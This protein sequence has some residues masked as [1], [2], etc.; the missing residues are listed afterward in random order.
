MYVFLKK[1]TSVDQTNWVRYILMMTKEGQPNC[2]FHDTQEKGGGL[3]L[4]WWHISIYNT[5]K[6]LWCSL[7]CHYW[8][9]YSMTGLL[10][11]KY[12]HFWQEVSLE[13]LILR[14]PLRPMGL[15]FSVRVEDSS[16]SSKVSQCEDDQPF[17][18]WPQRITQFPKIYWFIN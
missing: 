6:G 3:E 8:F 14:W 9:I 2:K 7:L 4:F 10:I 17:D 12:E 16:W 1:S 13:S 15:L 5:L 11:C 18:G